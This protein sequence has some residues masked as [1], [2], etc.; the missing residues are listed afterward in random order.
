MQIKRLTWPR[1]CIPWKANFCIGCP[2]ELHLF[3]LFL[4]T[5]CNKINYQIQSL[6]WVWF[7]HCFIDKKIWMHSLQN[8]QTKEQNSNNLQG[9]LVQPGI[10]R[11]HHRIVALCF[12]SVLALLRHY[13]LSLPKSRVLFVRES[14][15]NLD[16][17]CYLRVCWREI[18]LFCLFCLFVHLEEPGC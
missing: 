12:L 15:S 2:R 16:C 11:R 14:H 18:N 6:F 8:K 3:I 7:Y 13:I 10:T 17:V 9:I 4:S 1:K 5:W